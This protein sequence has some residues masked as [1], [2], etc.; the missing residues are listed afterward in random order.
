MTDDMMNLRALWF[1]KTSIPE[2]GTPVAGRS[3]D[4]YL[5]ASLVLRGVSP[6]QRMKS[7]GCTS[8]G[9]LL[10]YLSGTGQVGYAPELDR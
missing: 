1:L 3:V 7:A 2:F 4:G 5:F 10:K 6:G 9:R 8:V